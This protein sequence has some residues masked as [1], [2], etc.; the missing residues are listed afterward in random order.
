MPISR[1]SA[2]L[3]HQSSTWRAERR[4][5]TEFAAASGESRQ[6]QVQR[7]RAERE[8]DEADADPE[9]RHRADAVGVE[10]V[11]GERIEADAELA[12]GGICAMHR[13]GRHR[14]RVRL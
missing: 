13:V 2:G 9:S 1:F 7:V 11:L 14:G 8:K 5:H 10:V 3:A 6:Q 4:A 12:R